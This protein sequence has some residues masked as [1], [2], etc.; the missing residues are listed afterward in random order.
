MSFSV[1]LR[2]VLDP[3]LLW[4]QCTLAAAALIRLLHAAGAAL[5]KNAHKLQ[6]PPPSSVVSRA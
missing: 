2:R 3:T 4:L 6:F 1:G 5:R